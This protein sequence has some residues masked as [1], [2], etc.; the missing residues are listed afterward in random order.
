M[1]KKKNIHHLKTKTDEHY[2]IEVA[3]Q[4]ISRDSLYTLVNYIIWAWEAKPKIK[5]MDLL[6]VITEEYLNNQKGKNEKTNIV[7]FN[8]KLN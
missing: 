2:A 3:R 5:Q 7:R 4:I 8:P 1:K 6:N